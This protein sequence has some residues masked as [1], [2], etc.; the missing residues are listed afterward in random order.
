MSDN[1]R[2]SNEH[3]EDAN[4]EPAKAPVAVKPAVM[5]TDGRSGSYR[6]SKVEGNPCPELVSFSREAV[7]SFLNDYEWYCKIHADGIAD[8]SVDPKIKPRSIKS[9][10]HPNTLNSI[11]DLLLRKSKDVVESEELLSWM[12]KKIGKTEPNP[13]S[14][15][16]ILRRALNGIVKLGGKNDPDDRILRLFTTFDEVVTDNGWGSAFEGK[17]GRKQKIQFLVEATKSEPTLHQLVKDAL[18]KDAK[19]NRDVNRFFEVACAEANCVHKVRK[20]DELIAARDGII[21]R[22]SAQTKF[23]AEGNELKS[24][25]P[26]Q[27]KKPTVL[28]KGSCLECGSKEHKMADCPKK[29]SAERQRVLWEQHKKSKIA[30]SKNKPTN[31]KYNGFLMKIRKIG[32]GIG[33]DGMFKEVKVQ[34]SNLSLSCPALLDN[35]S[36]VTIIPRSV[37][38]EAEKLDPINFR[39]QKLPHPEIAT[40]A[41]GKTLC[42]LDA[43]IN[44]DLVLMS[45]AGEITFRNRKCFIWDVPNQD[46]IIGRDLLLEIGITPEQA[47]EMLID[48]VEYGKPFAIIDSTNEDGADHAKELEVS[49]IETESP[50]IG[51]NTD[52]D[53]Q[54]AIDRLIT[55]AVEKGL[56]SEWQT[57]L[58][59]LIINY[60]NVFRMKLSNDPAAAVTPL[61]SELIDNAKP[62]RCK[63]RRYGKPESDF[64]HEFVGKLTE[65]GLVYENRNSKWASPVVVVQKPGNRG[66]RMCVDLREVNKQCHSTMWPMPHLE[67]IVQHLADKQ[68]WFALD[69]FKGFWIM[70]LHPD[71]QEMMSFATDRGVY[72]PTRSIQGHLNSTVQF[73]ARMS[74]IFAEVMYKSLIIWVDDLLGYTRTVNEWFEALKKVLQLAEIS[75]LKL[76][77]DRCELFLSE[78]RFAGKIFTPNG[79]KHDSDRIKALV[80]I[81]TPKKAS[82]LQQFLCSVQWMQRHIPQY[83]SLVVKLQEVFENAMRNQPKRSKA[84]AR[85]ISLS[86]HGWD[87]EHDEAF[88]NL[89]NAIAN[90]VQLAYPK[91]DFIQCIFTD[92][93]KD[94]CAGIVTQIP[95]GDLGK[96]LSEQNH[97]PLGFSGHKWDRTQQNWTV[98]EW[99]AFAVK[100]CMEKLDYLLPTLGED[101]EPCRLYT[102]HKNLVSMFNPDKNMAKHTSAK[103]TRW[104]MDISRFNYKIEHIRGEDN[105]WADLMTRWGAPTINRMIRKLTV[106][107]RI[108]S[109]LHIRPL[110]RADFEWPNIE[111]IASSQKLHNVSS[112]KQNNEGL[113]IDWKERIVVPEEDENLHLRLAIVAHAGGN[114]GHVGISECLNLLQRVFS[115]KSMKAD[116]V[117]IAS[118]CLHCLP[119]R[120]G[121]RIPRPLGEQCHGEKAN[122]CLHYDF[123]YMEE[124]AKHANHDFKWVLVM[125]DD[126]TGYVRL[127]PCSEPTADIVVDSILQWRADFGTPRKLVS[128][129]GSYFKSKVVAELCRLTN[130]SLHFVVSYVH[131]PNG[132]VEVMNR[133]IQDLMKSLVSELRCDTAQWPWLIVH[134]QHT[135]N[136]RSQARLGNRAP[137]EL[138]TGVSPDNPVLDVVRSHVVDSLPVKP[139]TTN[140]L[141][142]HFDRLI[143]SLAEFHKT[144]QVI[145]SSERNKKRRKSEKMRMLNVEPGEYVLVAVPDPNRAPGGKLRHKWRGPFRVTRAISPWVYEVEDIVSAKRSNAH[146]E[147]LRLYADSQLDVDVDVKS[148]YCFDNVKYEIEQFLDV[149]RNTINGEFEMLTNWKGFEH[150]QDSWEPI[151]TLTTD[152]PELVKKFKLNPGHKL[153]KDWEMFI[154]QGRQR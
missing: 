9:A 43:V 20:A 99:E 42:D 95:K 84:I 96:P 145:T 128:D 54:M 67:A 3:Q 45:R 37:A 75:G 25:K 68:C 113:F 146:I 108:P 89:K 119:C 5:S 148:Q 35:G 137:V 134:V 71:S 46:I 101:R 120:G 125:L 33:D 136:H 48:S 8:G 109:S 94:H 83:H 55:R 92:A 107:T 80:Q 98:P 149:R 103:L 14:M 47:L 12:H 130:I 110:Q 106:N 123:L 29:P 21:K 17:D 62:V 117:R 151:G 63:S 133:H 26:K 97:E 85:S 127:V 28:V 129:Q 18:E 50:D 126:F 78:V 16:T 116:V 27:N 52:E 131:Y 87:K 32:I 56:P 70:P 111:V 69:A 90:S 143:K 36:D 144:A 100:S 15:S 114:S 135:L 19:L 153:K 122:D 139:P 152:V 124:L 150:D 49:E 6:S 93:N 22:K 147:R 142:L 121:R 140:E 64:L 105:T 51:I 66:Y 41:D 34:I 118:N 115:W 30:E 1:E 39:I 72:T 91:S 23:K 74:E 154:S 76:N 10:I 102:D 40:L 13:G 60:R 38:L 53:M 141:E 132:T 57:R 112:G 81:N 11:C 79:V 88:Q 31:S 77:I 104:G 73:Q 138:K 86:K 44:L 24:K 59:D 4:L 61:Q 82:D 58:T 7:V 2:N 65:Y